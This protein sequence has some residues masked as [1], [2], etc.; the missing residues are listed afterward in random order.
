MTTK[1]SDHYRAQILVVVLYL[2]PRVY[3]IGYQLANFTIE[4]LSLLR[5]EEFYRFYTFYFIY[6]IYYLLVYKVATTI[7]SVK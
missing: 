7:A 1:V 6:F 3:S 2:K 5:V 4:A